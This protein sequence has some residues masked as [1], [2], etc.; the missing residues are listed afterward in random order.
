M[1][2]TSD[3]L[4]MLA[5]LERRYDGPIPEPE[6]ALARHGSQQ[7]VLWLHALGQAAFFRRLI[8]GQ[9]RAIRQRRRDGSFYPALLS[10]LALYRREWRQWQRRRRTLETVTAPA[11]TGHLP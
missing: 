3:T 1:R 2:W 8:E 7:A 9:I 4:G 5:E 10:D 6:L 11:R